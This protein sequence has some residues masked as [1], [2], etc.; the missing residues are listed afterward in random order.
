MPP[1]VALVLWL[2][3]VVVLLRFDPARDPRTSLALWVP[4]IWM[5]F[6]ASR[7]PSQWLGGPVGSASQAL[8]EGNGMDRSVFAFL[9][10]L[11]IVTLLMRSFNWGGFFGRNFFLAI[12]LLFTLTSILWSDFPFVAFKRWF[13][14][15]GNYLVILVV[16][17]DPHPLEAVRTLLRRLCFLLIPLSVLLIKYF[18]YIGRQYETWSGNTI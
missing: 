1:S 17:S 2:I 9:I 12:F 4:V 3:F 14:D 10:L 8:E 13:R 15:F 16:I 7:L 18:I 6:V 11:A 5:F